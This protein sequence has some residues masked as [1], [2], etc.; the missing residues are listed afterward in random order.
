MAS[1]PINS[2][3]NLAQAL[4]TVHLAAAGPEFELRFS[5]LQNTMIRRLNDE[6]HA[7]NEAGGSKSEMLG[8]QSKGKRFAENLPIIEK[9]L[10][11]TQTNQ[12]RLST[13]FDKL[14]TLAGLFTGDDNISAAD[15]TTFNTVRQETVDEINKMWQLSYVGFTDGD[16]IR[17]I[18][19]AHV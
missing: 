1:G 8:L 17:Q 15:V 10:F 16:I 4:A 13:V 14:S 12:G 3:G 5:Q 7:V 9:F 19:R 6:I 11:D 18:G 2:V